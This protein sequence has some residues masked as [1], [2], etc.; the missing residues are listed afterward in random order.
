[1]CLGLVYECQYRKRPVGA[2]LVG[3]PQLVQR[4]V[5]VFFSHLRTARYIAGPASCALVRETSL[6]Q[7]AASA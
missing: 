4:L 3:S 6:T 1:V 7:S 2:A 5:T